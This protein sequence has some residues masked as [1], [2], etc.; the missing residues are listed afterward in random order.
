MP[1]VQ[2]LGPIQIEIWLPHKCNGTPPH[3]KKT[4]TSTINS[5]HKFETFETEKVNQ[6]YVTLIYSQILITTTRIFH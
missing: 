1:W 2:F 4:K 6:E 3:N 5:A